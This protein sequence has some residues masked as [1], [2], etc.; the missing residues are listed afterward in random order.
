MKSAD[1][2]PKIVSNRIARVKKINVGFLSRFFLFFQMQVSKR[3]SNKIIRLTISRG[4]IIS[5]LLAIIQD[6]KTLNILTSNLNYTRLQ[7]VQYLL[8]GS[9]DLIDI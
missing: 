2:F 6:E 3:L 5:L 9:S 7:K 1:D 8:N 4:Q